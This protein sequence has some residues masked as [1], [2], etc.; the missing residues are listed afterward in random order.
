MIVLATATVEPLRRSTSV[1]TQVVVPMSKL[2]PNI[3][4][5]VSPSSQS[6]RY[7]PTSVAVTFEPLRNASATLGSTSQSWLR[8]YPASS[9][10]SMTRRRCERWS[11]SEGEGSSR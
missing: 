8:V 2:A 1:Q 7:S 4:S 5:R 11:S 6:T 10:A 3:R 9:T